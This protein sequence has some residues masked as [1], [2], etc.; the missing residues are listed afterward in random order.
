MSKTLKYT[1]LVSLVLLCSG[2]A[3]NLGNDEMKIN[4]T[5]EI[6][7]TNISKTNNTTQI[8]E[9]ISLN[10][11]T[12]NE[13]VN[14]S[15]NQTIEEAYENA[16]RVK[17]VTK[18][19]VISFVHSDTTDKEKLTDCWEYAERVQK[20]ANDK[21]IRCGVV[22]VDLKGNYYYV[23]NCFEATDYG[24]IY[25]SSET[26]DLIATCEEGGTLKFKGLIKENTNWKDMG[27]IE[28]CTIYW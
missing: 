15:T 1:I 10:N 5:N 28:K 14:Q 17:D 4:V 9:P 13:S 16:V 24:M 12:L 2:C 21:G 11:A 20:N 26:W 6:I 18:R 3:G 8:N 23:L 7:T 25:T 27:T 22:R 19:E